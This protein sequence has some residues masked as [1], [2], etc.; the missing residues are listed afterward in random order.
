M[1]RPVV[2]NANGSVFTYTARTDPTPLIASPPTDPPS[3]NKG[4]LQIVMTVPPGGPYDVQSIAFTVDVGATNALM[5]SADDLDLPTPLDPNPDDDWS[6]AAL[7]LSPTQTQFTLS[8][9]DGNPIPLSGTAIVVEIANFITVEQPCSTIVQITETLSTSTE[10][11]TLTVTTFP[12]G[13]FFDSLGAWTEDGSTPV[14]EIAN[15]TPVQLQWN[16]SS[17]S[18]ITIYMSGQDPVTPENLGAWV[19]PPL[20]EDTVFTV[21]A[22]TTDGIVLSS[23]TVAVTVS[24]PV[25]DASSVTVSGPLAVSGSTNVANI[26]ASSATVNGP[27]TVSGNVSAGNVTATSLTTGSATVTG[28]LTVQNGW[29]AVQELQFSAPSQG[30]RYGSASYIPTAD[31]FVSGWTSG[32][33]N[34]S[35]SDEGLL[36]VGGYGIGNFTVFA[37][38]GP[39]DGALN[40]AQFFMPVIANQMFELAWGSLVGMPDD[41]S[42]LYVYM[43]YVPFGSGTA[44]YQPPPPPPSALSERIRELFAKRR[45]RDSRSTRPRRAS[46]C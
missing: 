15:N 46:T 41:T 37:T 32:W 17:E 26:T 39:V 4:A 12:E 40:D 9:S 42:T 1:T 18:T 11:P 43:Y 10:K 31:G 45:E 22:S 35:D 13:Y 7:T 2:V 34:A 19:S 36:T 23:S 5:Q 24:D 33:A 8:P 14:A 29:G 30:D 3:E 21:A 28:P 6:W 27:L 16:A 38:G 44:N 25:I 20:S